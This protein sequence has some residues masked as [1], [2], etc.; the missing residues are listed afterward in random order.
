MPF[1]YLVGFVVLVLC[2]SYGRAV[3]RVLSL[4]LRADL[5][6]ERVEP[7]DVPDD[8]RA[9]LDAQSR[10]LLE[11]GFE[12]LA[13]VCTPSLL[14]GVD[15][16]GFARLF[17][18]P[19]E[20]SFAGLSVEGTNRSRPCEVVF[21][22]QAD[23]GRRIE[24]ADWPLV[25]HH[26]G[27]AKHVMADA[28]TV[29]VD[30]AWELHKQAVAARLPDFAPRDISVDELLVEARGS[31]RCMI[32]SGIERGLFAPAGHGLARFRLRHAIATV[33]TSTGQDKRRRAALAKREKELRAQ[34]ALAP[35][36]APEPTPNDVTAEVWAH[37]RREE[38]E[39]S[40]R[41]GWAL[42][43]GLFALSMGAA[44]VAFGMS[45]SFETLVILL[46][47]LF[48]HEAGHALA[49]KA[50]GYRNLQILFIPFFG[51][52]ASGSKR[53]VPAW[54]EI[55]VLLAG[56]LPGIVVGTALYL[57]VDPATSPLLAQIAS[58]ML[59]LNYFNL[60]PI[61]PLDGGRILNIALFD[62]YPNLQLG[63][64]TLSGLALYALGATTQE[65]VMRFLGLGLLLGIPAQWKNTRLLAGARRR[66]AEL[67]PA[68]DPLAPLRALYSELRQP[69]FD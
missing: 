11:L 27:C 23:E 1:G 48:A 55:V 66:L 18:H 60:L 43:L 26:A 2:L 38:A 54:Q 58:T 62:R 30:E 10:E 56:P 47:V 42:K 21:T 49:M 69:R 14:D 6:S 36:P 7:G 35:T 45:L 40:R 5:P 50:F 57:A 37:Q 12:P 44:A 9:L 22:A 64:A 16:P 65:P 61:V 59:I 4:R 31:Y 67:G 28:R 52:V 20:K 8:V 32:T 33:V 24:T 17:Q 29:A 51:A 13:F 53:E 39:R 34:G 3:L 68:P 46:G 41:S 25:Q 63:F 15:R 19:T